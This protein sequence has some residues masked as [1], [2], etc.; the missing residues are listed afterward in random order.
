[1]KTTKFVFVIAF[2][3]FAT[4]IFAQA[5]ISSQVDPEPIQK[6]IKISLDKAIQNPRL[7]TAMHQQL[8]V[9][10]LKTYL[11]EIYT[12]KVYF[13]HKVYYISGTYNQWWMFF[14]KAL[15]ENPKR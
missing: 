8:S 9:R 14:N 1:M 15:D 4:M 11:A 13:Q 7:V 2:V 5:G 3:A 10:M 6:C 12:P